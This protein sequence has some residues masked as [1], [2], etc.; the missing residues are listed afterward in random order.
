MA[1]GCACREEIVNKSTMC[2]APTS[3]S[4]HIMSGA[5]AMRIHHRDLNLPFFK[6]PRKFLDFHQVDEA[7]IIRMLMLMEV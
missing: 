1:C 5:I 4:C 2:G 6:T 7:V 3:H